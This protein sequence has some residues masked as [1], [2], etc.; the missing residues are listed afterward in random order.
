[1][2][3]EK[4]LDEILKLEKELETYYFS[5]KEIKDEDIQKI[6]SKLETLRSIR[7]INFFR[8]VLEDDNK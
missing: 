6:R 8:E 2:T 5:D 1:M 3:K 7:E 4:I